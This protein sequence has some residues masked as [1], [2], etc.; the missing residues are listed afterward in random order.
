MSDPLRC[1]NCRLW[2]ENAV[3]ELM[4]RL[5]KGENLTTEQLM[6]LQRNYT[7]DDVCSCEPI[8]SRT[9][10]FAVNWCCSN[11]HWFQQSL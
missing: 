5:M 3:S 2:L 11:P 9:H 8:P 6:A 7:P 1:D 10:P 4:I